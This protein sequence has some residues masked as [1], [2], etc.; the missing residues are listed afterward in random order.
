M[1]GVSPYLQK[2]LDQSFVGN[3]FEDLK[4]AT[5]LNVM[6][7]TEMVYRNI[8]FLNVVDSTE[9]VY[10]NITFK[11]DPPFDGNDK[12]GVVGYGGEDC[13][14]TEVYKDNP[15]SCRLSKRGKGLYL[16]IKFSTI[17]KAIES[18]GY[19]IIGATKE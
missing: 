4:T 1:E 8:T 2:L 7:S 10:R 16:E 13:V 19:T 11:M 15:T 12:I 14:L 9:M 18:L 6:D 5:V 3:P 17:E